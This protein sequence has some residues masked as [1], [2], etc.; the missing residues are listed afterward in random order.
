MKLEIT[1]SVVEVYTVRWKERSCILFS[2]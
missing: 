1:W 2:T